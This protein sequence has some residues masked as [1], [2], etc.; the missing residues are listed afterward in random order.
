MAALTGEAL[1]QACAQFGEVN[2]YVERGKI[3]QDL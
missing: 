3:Y 1:S 2:L